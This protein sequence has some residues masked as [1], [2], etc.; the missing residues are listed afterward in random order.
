MML[1][2]RD[3]LKQSAKSPVVKGIINRAGSPSEA[4]T[5]LEETFDPRSSGVIDKFLD[6]L[7]DASLG[8]GES[9][10]LLLERMEDTAA[11]LALM[12][13]PQ[14][15]RTINSTFLKCLP[16]EYEHEVQTLRGMRTYDGGSERAMRLS[17]EIVL[18]E[19]TRSRQGCVSVGG[20]ARVGEDGGET[21]ATQ[22]SLEATEV[23]LPASEDA[24][25][26]VRPA[27]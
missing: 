19:A 2:T 7:H 12:G 27:I 11:R 8:P 23:R 1:S 4:W 5:A 6:E 20:G 9:P 3:T 13:E 24:T 15:E 25:C 26:A 10:C 18:R 16:P 14:T 22:E 21:A 17:R